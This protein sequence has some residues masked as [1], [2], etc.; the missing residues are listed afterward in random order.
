MQNIFSSSEEV[1]WGMGAARWKATSSNKELD[2]RKQSPTQN[3]IQKS[4][5]THLLSK[6]AC[7][8][9]ENDV[10][11][12]TPLGFKYFFTGKYMTI[13]SHTTKMPV[14]SF[15]YLKCNSYVIWSNVFMPAV[16]QTVNLTNLVQYFCFACI[17]MSKHTHNRSSQ[18]IH[19]SLSLSIFFSFLKWKTEK[20]S[21]INWSPSQHLYRTHQFC[22]LWD[23]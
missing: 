18:P 13:C 4:S 11:S 15:S 14:L 1:D 3:S 23:C 8:G 21:T 22:N 10:M 7:W 5:W 12:V 19:G 9:W 17:N 20:Q 6:R 2:N 16:V